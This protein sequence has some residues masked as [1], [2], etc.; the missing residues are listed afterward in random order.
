MDNWHPSVIYDLAIYRHH[1]D[2]ARGEAAQQV[3][4][5]LSGRPVRNRL[6]AALVAL[7]TRL[8]PALRAQDR[9]SPA[10]ATA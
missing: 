4:S 9:R 1:E 2:T 10:T 6:A 5:Q 8:D 3:A 7:A